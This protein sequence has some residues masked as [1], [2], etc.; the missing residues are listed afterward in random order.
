MLAGHGPVLGHGMST[1]PIPLRT[2]HACCTPFERFI[3]A[4]NHVGKLPRRR[5]LT[6]LQRAR[7][8]SVASSESP[9]PRYGHT[10]IEDGGGGA[11]L[12]GGAGDG[13]SFADLW[14]FSPHQ[15]EELAGNWAVVEAAGAPKGRFEPKLSS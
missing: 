1:H 6:L 3:R 14:Q 8:N 13:L 11:L 7:R 2:R 12:F 4:G 5:V 10:L 15:G 9:P